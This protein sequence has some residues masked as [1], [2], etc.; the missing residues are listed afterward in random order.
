M[1]LYKCFYYLLFIFQCK[2]SYKDG[3]SFNTY[4]HKVFPRQETGQQVRK[5]LQTKVKCPKCQKLFHPNSLSQH[6][7]S[8]HLSSPGNVISATRFLTSICVDANNGIYLVRKYFSGGDYVIHVQFKTSDPQSF[9]CT[10]NHCK[11]LS[12]TAERSGNIS[13]LCSHLKSISFCD[14]RSSSSPDLEEATLNDL[15]F[16]YKWLKPERIAECQL[17]QSQAYKA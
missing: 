15:V 7:R 2:S 17:L 3:Q 10:S 16:K 4:F 1:F 9:N 12:E 6:I 11:Q 14:Q 13:F 5:S 8:Q